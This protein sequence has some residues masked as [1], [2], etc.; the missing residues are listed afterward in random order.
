MAALMAYTGEPVSRV[1][2]S[3]STFNGL[4]NAGAVAFVSMVLVAH[5]ANMTLRP[6]V[7]CAA[8]LSP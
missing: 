6:M 2:G 4:F 5:Q 1:C 8:V 3:D 7:S